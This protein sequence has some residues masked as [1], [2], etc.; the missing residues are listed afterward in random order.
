MSF[1]RK[2]E[3]DKI[4][5]ERYPSNIRPFIYATNLEFFEICGIMLYREKWGDIYA[6]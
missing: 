3:I 2:H 6:H 4:E 5:V 1:M